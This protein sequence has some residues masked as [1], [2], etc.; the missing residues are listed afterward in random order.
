MTEHLTDARVNAM[1]LLIL[2]LSGIG[3]LVAWGIVRLARARASIRESLEQDGCTVLRMQRQIFR[4]G[5]FLWTTTS[6]QVVY[7]IL[8]RDRAG[9]DRTVWA[10]WGRTWLPRP[11]QL[12]LRWEGEE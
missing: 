3:S 10:R 2:A 7:R 11:D 9:H 1:F 12:E 4:Q 6:S 8:V 5:P